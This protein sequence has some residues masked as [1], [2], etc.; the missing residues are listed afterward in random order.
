MIPSYYVEQQ[1]ASQLMNETRELDIKQILV[2]GMRKRI[3][4]KKV[5]CVGNLLV[6][7][8]LRLNG[9]R[10]MVLDVRSHIED[11]EPKVGVFFGKPVEDE[12]SSDM[13]LTTHE[14]H[15]LKKYERY[16][17]HVKKY[18][19]DWAGRDALREAEEILLLK[20]EISLTHECTWR[21]RWED[22]QRDYFYNE[23]GL[24]YDNGDGRGLRLLE[25]FIIE[26]KG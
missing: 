6:G 4:D 20:N 3:A 2:D 22:A 25:T 24:Y 9:Q 7:N 1:L 17:L 10:F 16:W 5:E 21:F 8:L 26:K 11:K 13:K 15:H 23:S 18:Q 19:S 14:K 12:V